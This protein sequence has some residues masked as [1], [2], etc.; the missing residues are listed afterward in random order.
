[1]DGVDEDMIDKFW[2]AIERTNKYRTKIKG[3]TAVNPGLAGK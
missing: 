3:V 1:M 2:L